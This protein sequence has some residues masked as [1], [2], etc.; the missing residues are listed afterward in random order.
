MAIPV[1]NGPY[2]DEYVFWFDVSVEDAVPV[3]VVDGL[4]EL[5]HVEPDSLL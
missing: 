2:L 4:A 5:V 1:G 3:H